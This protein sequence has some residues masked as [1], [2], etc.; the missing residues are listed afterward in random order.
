MK[1]KDQELQQLI[2][3]P[4]EKAHVPLGINVIFMKSISSKRSENKV[5]LISEKYK[6]SDLF[7]FVSE[8]PLSKLFK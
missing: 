6:K 4:I 3:T 8:K 7:P 1:N 2:L 5:T